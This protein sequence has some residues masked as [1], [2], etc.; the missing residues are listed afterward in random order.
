MRRWSLVWAVALPLAALA[1]PLRYQL[2][3]GQDLRYRETMTAKGALVVK[4]ALGD[5]AIPVE[6]RGEED[7]SMKCVEAVADGSF[8]LES[9]SLAAKATI[10][11]EGGTQEQQ[12]PGTNLRLRVKP[13]GEVLETKQLATTQR[14]ESQLD[15]HLDSLV[16]AARLAQFPE[17][18]LQVGA[19]WDKEIPVRDPSGKK[20]TAKASSKLKSVKTEGGRSLAEI[21]TRYEVPIPE[22][23]GT[24]QMGGLAIPV[25]VKGKSS[26]VSTTWWDVAGGRVR[27]TTGTGKVALELLLVGLATEPATSSFDVTFK[28]EPAAK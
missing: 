22:T 5:Q 24:L 23:Q 3:V 16:D 18:D 26:G 15:L 21:E 27:T 8:W 12:V 11:M 28:I 7:R 1:V 19:T 25:Q 6:V 10:I 17:G 13:S 20:Q 4:S 9:R 2:T 14:G